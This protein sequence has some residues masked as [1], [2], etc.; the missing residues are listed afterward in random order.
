MFSLCFLSLV[1]LFS[2]TENTT[3]LRV[4]AKRSAGIKLSGRKKAGDN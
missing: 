2:L 4:Y 1:F 3:K